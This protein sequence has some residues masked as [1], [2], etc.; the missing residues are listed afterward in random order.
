MS[1]H[2]DK[3][4]ALVAEDAPLETVLSAIQDAMNGVREPLQRAYNEIDAD[5]WPFLLTAL[6][7]SAVQLRG[8]MNPA[9]LKLA[10]MLKEIVV[11]V[12]VILPPDDG[13]LPD[14]EAGT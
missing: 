5:D 2:T 4:A 12:S 6:E 7:I 14:E 11:G 1:N 3:I 13:R 8:H 9:A 10:E